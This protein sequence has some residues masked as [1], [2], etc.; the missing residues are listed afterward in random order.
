MRGPLSTPREGGAVVLR[1]S[2]FE[3]STPSISDPTLTFVGSECLEVGASRCREWYALGVSRA[4]TA[5]RPAAK[6][7][8]RAVF[9][10][11]SA[12]NRCLLQQLQTRCLNS[13]QER[14]TCLSKN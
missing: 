8:R 6:D 10:Y 5:E 11:S 9:F 13:V 4:M 14:R 7:P 3:P 2:N 1:P 12:L